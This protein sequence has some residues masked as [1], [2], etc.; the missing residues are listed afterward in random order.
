MWPNDPGFAKGMNS[1]TGTAQ[2]TS[3]EEETQRDTIRTP[4][5]GL[6]VP[7]FYDS[8]EEGGGIFILDAGIAWKQGFESLLRHFLSWHPPSWFDGASCGALPPEAS[9]FPKS[10]P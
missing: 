6:G 2:E 10:W 1:R 8:C 3:Y 9:D 4:R 7:I 5:A